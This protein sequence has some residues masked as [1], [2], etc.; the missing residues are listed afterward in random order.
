M[1]HYKEVKLL[2]LN[3]MFKLFQKKKVKL[4]DSKEKLKEQVYNTMYP[5]PCS[6]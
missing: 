4:D 5:S 6:S 3:W 2:N 1:I